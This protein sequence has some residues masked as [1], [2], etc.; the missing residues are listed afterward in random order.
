MLRD[1]KYC[2]R[3][4]GVMFKRWIEFKRITPSNFRGHYENYSGLKFEVC[5]DSHS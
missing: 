2:V 5:F 3:G 4:V 1:H